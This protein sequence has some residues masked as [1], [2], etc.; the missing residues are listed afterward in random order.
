[1]SS[2]IFVIDDDQDILELYQTLLESEGYTVTISTIAYEQVRDVET[3]HPDLIILDM[4]VGEQYQGLLL[5]QKLR[6]YPPTRAIPVIMC[7]A[8]VTL[9]REQEETLQAKGIP[10]IYKPFDIDELLQVIRQLLPSP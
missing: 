10:I 9:M 8:A 1:M 5:L 3:L 7:S 2:H 4:K 6:M